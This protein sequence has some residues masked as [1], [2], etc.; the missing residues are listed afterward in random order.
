[1]PSIVLI[2]ESSRIV[3]GDVR[4]M[5]GAFDQQWNHDLKAPLR[6]HFDAGKGWMQVN[7]ANANRSAR[8]ASV[9]KGS[10]HEPRA[11][12]AREPLRCSQRRWS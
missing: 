8:G 5:L 4:A 10:R 6:Q 2:T 7:R 12:Q 11:R 1:M 9:A 3:D